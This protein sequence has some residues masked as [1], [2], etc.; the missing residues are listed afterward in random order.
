MPA[1]PAHSVGRGSRRDYRR[2][3]ET[4]RNNATGTGSGSSGSSSG[5]YLV[6]EEDGTS[7][8]TLEDGS[9]SLLKEA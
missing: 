1:R 8:Y 2:V 9:G 5:T 6:R 4:L 7:R 3:T